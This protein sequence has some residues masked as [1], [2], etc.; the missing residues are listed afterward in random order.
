M[1]MLTH[2]VKNSASQVVAFVIQCNNKDTMTVFHSYK[3]LKY[4][5]VL[6]AAH[7]D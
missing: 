6:C 4:G 1:D 5:S 3:L 2:S 7:N